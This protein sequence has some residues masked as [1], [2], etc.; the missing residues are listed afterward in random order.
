MNNP[1]LA[2]SY[3]D[4]FPPERFARFSADVE[5]PSLGILIESRPEPGPFA[6]LEWLIPTAVIVYI[7][8]SYFESFLKEMGKDHYVLLKRGL[9][10]LGMS[11]LGNNAPK[12]YLIG[13]LG[14]V[15]ESNEKYSLIFSIV[16]EVETR[17]RVKLLLQPDL[18]ESAYAE[19]LD[20]FLQFLEHLHDGTISSSEVKGLNEARPVAGTLLVAF[21]SQKKTLEVID[22]IP[23][24]SRDQI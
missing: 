10:N 19:A 23:R 24:K 5:A 20:K 9:K 17:L 8:K 4:K 21:N 1:H 6:A 18:S 3:I 15:R 2:V 11:L 14:K 13:T 7:A 12:I 16:A 22:P